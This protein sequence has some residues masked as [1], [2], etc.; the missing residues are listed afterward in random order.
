[1]KRITKALIT[2]SLLTILT[3]APLQAAEICTFT[4]IGIRVWIDTP[5]AT[6][7]RILAMGNPDSSW[8]IWKHVGVG[9]TEIGDWHNS[10]TASAGCTWTPNNDVNDANTVYMPLITK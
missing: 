1:M 3:I 9:V 5:I 6:T 8:R 7:V 4:K 2:A 10:Y